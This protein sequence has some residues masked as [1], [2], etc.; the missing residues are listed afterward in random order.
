MNLGGPRARWLWWVALGLLLANG[1]VFTLLLFPA[2]E[3][4]RQE[5]NQ[6]LDLQRRIRVLQREGESSEVI[7]TA[8]R[9]V[10]EFSQGYPRRA[11][12][13]ANIGRLTKLARSLAL[14]VPAVQY[15][16]SEVKEAGLTKVTLQMAVEGNYGKIRRYLHELEGLRRQLVIE[17]VSLKDPKGTSDLQ[18]QLQVAL[19]LR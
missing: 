13:V 7:L 3:G 11:D 10:E 9:E 1:L 18:V 16:P 15:K 12:L 19:Y 17:R 6:L 2:R 5:E 14:E 4:R 8:L